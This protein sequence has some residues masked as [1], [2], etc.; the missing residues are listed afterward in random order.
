M[1][2]VGLN[3]NIFFKKKKNMEIYIMDISFKNISISHLLDI[4]HSNLCFLSAFA[5]AT[6]AAA[7]SVDCIGCFGKG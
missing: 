3:F 6:A 4:F 2:N 1:D 7:A 5:A